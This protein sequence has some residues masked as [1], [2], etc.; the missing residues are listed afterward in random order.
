MAKTV[1]NSLRKK[2]APK[3]PK[4]NASKASWDAYEKKANA[5]KAYNKAVD[6]EKARRQRISAKQ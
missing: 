6:T 2:K 3:R 4:M 5:V 1:I